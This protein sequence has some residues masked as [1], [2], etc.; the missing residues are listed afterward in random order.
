MLDTAKMTKLSTMLR[1][2]PVGQLI[3][4]VTGARYLKYPEEEPGFQLPWESAL[5]EEK[6]HEAA[7]DASG[8]TTNSH[9]STTPDLVK[10]GP[11]GTPD[12]EKT[13]P[14]YDALTQQPT[15]RSQIS[16][17]TKLTTSRTM[18]REQTRPYTNERF[19]T[20]QEEAIDRAQSSVIIPTRTEDGIILVDWYTTDDD[21]NPQNWTSARKAGAT[22]IIFFYTFVAYCASAIYTSS[23]IGVME[24]FHVEQT[25]AALGELHWPLLLS[26]YPVTNTSQAYRY[27]S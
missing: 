27:M 6:A 2:A 19:Q 4:L 25:K 10:D 5:A 14:N 11:I 18:T 13:D 24:R 7:V 8:Q 1:D 3:R 23:E 12:L 15:M 9:S 26:I 21:A 16:R 17:T 22:A 20:E